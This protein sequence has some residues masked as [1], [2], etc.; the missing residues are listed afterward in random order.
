MNLLEIQKDLHSDHQLIIIEKLKKNF[1]AVCM[2]RNV[3][4][5]FLTSLSKH[6]KTCQY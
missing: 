5:K 4:N 1:G 3:S 6:T 2:P